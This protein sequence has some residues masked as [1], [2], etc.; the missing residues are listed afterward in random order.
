MGM[1]QNTVFD[2]HR[3]ARL[4]EEDGELVGFAWLEEPDGV[5]MQEVHPRLRGSGSLENEMLGW[6]A[7][8]TR[9]VYGELAGD[10]LWT[11]VAE[12]EP[13][14]DR[15]LF[16]LGFARDPD[17]AMKMVRTLDAPPDRWTVREVGGEGEW[18]E[19]V[20][21]RRDVWQPSQVTLEAYRRLRAAPGYDPRLDLV[22]VAPDGKFDSY[23][24]CWFDPESRTGL[25][26]PLGTR[27]AYRG[28]GLGAGP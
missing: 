6:P 17:R 13:R 24:I 8:L 16:G 27:Q 23:C 4:W 2:V 5:E 20:E 18:E 12:D 28:R 15:L 25:F 14:L 9:A 22:A 19:R 21:V 10:E 26:E 1:Y 7:P 11:R 3:E